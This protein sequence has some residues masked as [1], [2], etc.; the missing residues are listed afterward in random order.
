MLAVLLW[1]WEDYAKSQW[2][3][4]Q[5]IF[6]T[7][8]ECIPVGCVPP[9]RYRTGGS[10]SGGSL[11]EGLCPG[12]S[13]SR[14]SLSRVSLCPG[15]GS[16]K[17]GL[18]RGGLCPGHLCLGVVSV[19]GGLCLGGLPDRDPLPHLWTESQT[20]VKTFPCSNF[21]AGGNHSLLS[22]DDPHVDLHADLYFDQYIV[23]HILSRIFNLENRT[24][25]VATLNVKLILT[26]K[27]Q[28]L[29]TLP[30]STMPLRDPEGQGYSQCQS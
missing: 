25:N 24:Y 20:R 21:V 18:C 8:Q 10:L 27:K 17:G 12:E 29:M 6:Q 13:L 7:K 9:A 28:H 15:W 1:F 14:G 2:L 11:S 3:S 4:C 5:Q 30:S 23:L 26:V 16:V 22:H 19:Q